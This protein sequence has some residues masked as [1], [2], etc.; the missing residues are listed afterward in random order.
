MNLGRFVSTQKR[1]VLL[2]IALLSIGGLIAL[3]RIPRAL[4]PQTDFPRII[5][6]AENGVA[7][8]QQTLVAVTRPIEEAMSGIPGIAR[9]KSTTARGGSEVNLFFDWRTDIV[10]TLQLVQ[11]KVSQLAASLP[12]GAQILRADRLTFA[13]FPVI[14]YSITSPKRDPGTLRNLADVVLRPPLSRIDRVA[15]VNVLGGPSREYHILVDRARPERRAVSLRQL[16]HAM[17]G[18]NGN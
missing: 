12:P 7:P 9:I 3:A 6:T 5:I 18:A 15:S 13:V 4:F 11:A 8:A 16:A 14:G 1:A 10:L 2:V 17:T